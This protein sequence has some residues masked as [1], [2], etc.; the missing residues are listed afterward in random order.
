[1]GFNILYVFDIRTIKYI[2]SQLQIKTPQTGY[3]TKKLE[4]NFCKF[5]ARIGEYSLYSTPYFIWN[6]KKSFAPTQLPRRSHCSPPWLQLLERRSDF[7]ASKDA[8]KWALSVSSVYFWA[9]LCI[10]PAQKCQVAVYVPNGLF[11]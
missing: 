5:I 2:C 6:W 7:R 4:N 1:M 9:H 11:G 8:A 10:V 3:Q